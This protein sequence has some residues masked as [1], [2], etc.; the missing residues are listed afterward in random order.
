MF[1]SCF[2]SKFKITLFITVQQNINNDVLITNHKNQTIKE[3]VRQTNLLSMYDSNIKLIRNHFCSVVG[4]I[5]MYP[6]NKLHILLQLW[7]SRFHL[8]ILGEE[9]RCKS[10]G[11]EKLFRTQSEILT[12][13]GE[14]QVSPLQNIKHQ[15]L[16]ETEKMPTKWLTLCIHE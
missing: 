16:L 11:T 1:W 13:Y 6:Y 12:K 4:Q 8:V 9:F 10:Q 14:V 3:W 5:N 7:P 15:T 2:L